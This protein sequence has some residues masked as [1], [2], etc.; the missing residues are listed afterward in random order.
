MLKICNQ[1]FVGLIWNFALWSPKLTRKCH[2]AD[3][4]YPL[5][6]WWQ[7]QNFTPNPTPKFEENCGFSVAKENLS[8]H[9]CSCKHMV[10]KPW[11]GAFGQQALGRFYVRYHPF[12][13][14]VLA[15]Y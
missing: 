10:E 14:F 13:Y 9:C 7:K 5:Q 3:T 2:D 1:N 11:I 15:E 12:Y 4:D 6:F 8:G